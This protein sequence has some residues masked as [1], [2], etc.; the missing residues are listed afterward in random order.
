MFGSIDPARS[1][2]RAHL[3]IAYPESVTVINTIDHALDF[4][5][6]RRTPQWPSCENNE[7]DNEGGNDGALDP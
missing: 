2:F 7:T 6:S 3:G 5:R 1:D 4:A